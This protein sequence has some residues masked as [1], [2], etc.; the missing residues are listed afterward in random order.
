[1]YN[2]T[3]T[4]QLHRNVT[5]PQTN[6]A[7]YYYATQRHYCTAVTRN[8]TINI[9]YCDRIFLPITLHAKQ[10]VAS[11]NYWTVSLCMCLSHVPGMPV[12]T[13]LRHVTFSNLRSVWLCPIFRNFFLKDKTVGKNDRN[14]R[15]IAT[16]STAVHWGEL[17][18]THTVRTH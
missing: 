3:K 10:P 2:A 6:D 9:K 13:S 14:Q 7:K 17:G 4:R 12:G 8:A 18:M 16:F 5:S 11:N 15:C 1:M